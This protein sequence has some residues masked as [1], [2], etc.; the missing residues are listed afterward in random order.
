METSL[1]PRKFIPSSSRWQP[2][3]S[4]KLLKSH[5]FLPIRRHTPPL[6]H[7]RPWVRVGRGDPVAIANWTTLNALVLHVRICGG[8]GG[9]I[10]WG[11]PSTHPTDE[12]VR[13]GVWVSW[14]ELIMPTSTGGLWVILSRRCEKT[15]QTYQPKEAARETKR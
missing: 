8:P 6:V 11:Y 15:P 3:I 14:C 10:P 12:I 1:G 5:T 7:G 2:T 4:S 9:E 13:V